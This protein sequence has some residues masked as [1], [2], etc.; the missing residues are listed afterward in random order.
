MNIIKFLKKSKSGFGILEIV[1]VTFIISI[2]MAGVLALVAQS[3]QAKYITKNNLI[4]S[5]LAQE[6]LELVRNVRDENWFNGDAFDLD[7]SNGGTNTFIVDYEGRSSID[8]A[9]NNI[10]EAGAVLENRNDGTDDNFYRP[11]STLGILTNFRRLITVVDQGDYLEVAS[12]VRYNISG[13]FRD[14]T[15]ETLLYD[16]Y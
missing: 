11:D 1:V 13:G 16:W 2:G 7:I 8:N 14:Y 12:T 15:A 6:G 3:M 5:Q 9:I 10:D 4:A